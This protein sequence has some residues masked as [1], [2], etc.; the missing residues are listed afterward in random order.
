ML[1]LSAQPVHLEHDPV[2]GQG[3]EVVVAG[4]DSDRGRDA[5]GR[6]DDGGRCA[7]GLRKL[8]TR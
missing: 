7:G 5:G 2:Q 4:G 6:H 1:A 8:W 3:G